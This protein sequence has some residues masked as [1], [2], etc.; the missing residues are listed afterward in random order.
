MVDSRCQTHYSRFSELSDESSTLYVGSTSF[1]IELLKTYN[2]STHHHLCS[3]KIKQE[4]HPTNLQDTR[5]GQAVIQLHEKKRIEL[6]SLVQTAYNVSYKKH[7]F[8]EWS[9][10]LQQLNGLALGEN[11]SNAKGCQMF[12][13]IISSSLCEE[14]KLDLGL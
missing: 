1:R 10:E 5:L 14:N 2:T 13:N 8:A 6:E 3:S 9:C 11:Y 12:M 7:P 4:L